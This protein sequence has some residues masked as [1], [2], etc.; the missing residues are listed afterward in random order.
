MGR[1]TRACGTQKGGAVV[2]REPF[3][4]RQ[5]LPRARSRADIRLPV[6]GAVFR[7]TVHGLGWPLIGPSGRNSGKAKR[8]DQHRFVGEG[9]WTADQCASSPRP[10]DRPGIQSAHFLHIIYLIIYADLRISSMHLLHFLQKSG[11]N[12]M[13][14]KDLNYSAEFSF[15]EVFCA[16]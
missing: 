2:Y 12:L 3:S 5:R 11:R 14:E 16:P 9:R 7:P 13:L 15:G 1:Y 8:N 6:S 10:D 4:G